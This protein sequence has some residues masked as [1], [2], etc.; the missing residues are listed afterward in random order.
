MHFRGNFFS[1]RTF[2]T[3]ELNCWFVNSLL[4]LKLKWDIW[5]IGNK[6]HCSWC[7]GT[8]VIGLL[9]TVSCITDFRSL[10]NHNVSMIVFPH[11]PHLFPLSVCLFVGFFGLLSG[12]CHAVY[13]YILLIHE[14]NKLMLYVCKTWNTFWI[15]SVR[16]WV[17]R[18]NSW[19]SHSWNLAFLIRYYSST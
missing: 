8:I 16:L 6:S 18:H 1:V 10:W 4:T 9:H 12:I 7:C 11:L 5:L 3:C 15:Y 17:F 2:L 14:R 13:I 19:Y